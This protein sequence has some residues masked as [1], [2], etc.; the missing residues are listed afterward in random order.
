MHTVQQR[1]SSGC[2]RSQWHKHFQQRKERRWVRLCQERQPSD[3][4]RSLMDKAAS[5]QGEDLEQHV[6]LLSGNLYPQALN[7]VQLGIGPALHLSMG[8]HTQQGILS[9][10][11]NLVMNTDPQHKLQDWLMN[12]HKKI[13]LDKW[14]TSFVQL[15]QRSTQG[16]RAAA[17]RRRRLLGTDSQPGIG[18]K[19][20]RRQENTA[21]Y[22]R[23]SL[24]WMSRSCQ[25]D[26]ARIG[27]RQQQ[28]SGH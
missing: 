13:Q 18:C 2:F 8:T 20:S 1:T 9:M 22:H 16:S 6:L 19:W 15:R 10:K 23:Q 11:W 26:K 5:G 4:P 27:M 17:Q 7:N 24:L 25:E 3:P 21:H 12:L 28:S 14:C